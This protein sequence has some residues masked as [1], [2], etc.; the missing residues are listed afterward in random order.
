MTKSKILSL[1]PTQ[2]STI[3]PGRDPTYNPFLSFCN[4]TQLL[5]LLHS[6]LLLGFFLVRV[7][8][9]KSSDYNHQQR[10]QIHNYV[11]KYNCI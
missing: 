3:A 4:K 1:F 9:P 10:Q 11:H 2:D 7:Q 8:G 6:H 5:L